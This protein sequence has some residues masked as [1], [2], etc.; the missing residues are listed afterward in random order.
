MSLANGIY[1]ESLVL[2]FFHEWPSQEYVDVCD[3]GLSETDYWLP[4][5][6]TPQ[7]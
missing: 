1:I 4:A 2:L 5:R 3:E 7:E 6:S